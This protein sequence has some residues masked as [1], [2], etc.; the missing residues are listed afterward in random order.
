VFTAGVQL[1]ANSIIEKAIMGM[2]QEGTPYTG[3][4]Y[5]GGILINHGNGPTLYVVEFNAR[6]G[7]PEAQV[8]VPAI[9]ADLYEVGMR[10]A[11]GQLSGLDINTDGKSR[12]AVAGVA[13]GYPGNYKAAMGKQIFRLDEAEKM[14]GVSIYGAGIKIESGRHYI[15]GG[16][17]FYLVGEGRNIIEAREKAYAALSHI[18]SEDNMV[19]FR[20]DIGWRDAQRLARK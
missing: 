12:V 8:I 5:L 9:T 4:L 2:R 20:H 13:K 10:I 16:R 14:D 3:I 6:W 7:D 15:N 18:Q 11:T 17:I 1:Q 19:D